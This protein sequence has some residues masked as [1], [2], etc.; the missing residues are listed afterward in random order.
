MAVEL[1]LIVLRCVDIEAARR[2]Y[3]AIGLSW[4]EEQHAGGPRHYSA[5]VGAILFELYP[6]REAAGGRVRLAFC[7]ADAQ[8]A[9]EAAVA[10]GGTRI[11]GKGQSEAVVV[12]DPNGNHVELLPLRA[13][14]A[15]EPAAGLSLVA[16]RDFVR[17][18]TSGPEDPPPFDVGSVVQLMLAALEN[19]REHWIEADLDQIACAVTPEQRRHLIEIGEYLRDHDETSDDEVC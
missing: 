3:E 2:F 18:Y 11:V 15:V 1:S 10:A 19:L 8:Q 9:A 17:S 12:G 13:G 4:Q 5:R 14:A 16:V 7:V 6:S